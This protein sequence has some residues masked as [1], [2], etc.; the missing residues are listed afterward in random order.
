MSVVCSPLSRDHEHR[1]GVAGGRRGGCRRQRRAAPEAV[2]VVACRGGQ[3]RAHEATD[4][5]HQRSFDFDRVVEL[6]L[7]SE[8]GQV[9]GRKVEAADKRDLA[10]GDDDLAVHAAKQ[11]RAIAPQ[12]RPRVEHVHAHAGGGERRDELRRQVRR[13]VAV[14]RQIDLHAALGG[15]HQHL[16][17]RDADLVFEQDEGLDQ[18]L[19][20]CA[21][22]RVEHPRVVLLAAFEQHDAVAADPS[23]ADRRPLVHR[24]RRSRSGAALGLHLTHNSISAASGAWSDKCDHGCRGSTTG[25]CTAALRT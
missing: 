4:L 10:V 20:A 16:V 23:F 12:L 13:A 6:R 5:G 7:R 1:V 25:A 9:V 11:V 18:H 21:V 2:P 14:D 24:V 8:V 3:L 17:Q 15:A 22:D 19:V